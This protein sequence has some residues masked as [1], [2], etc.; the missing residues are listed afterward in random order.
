MAYPRS[1]QDTIGGLYHFARMVDKV[2]LNFSGDLPD[3]YKERLGKGMDGFLC[4]FLGVEYS[5]IVTQVK[6]GKADEKILEWCFENG[7]PRSEFD[8]TLFNKFL[9]KL[10]WRD[11]DNGISKRL[12]DYKHDDG[13]AN[14]T[15]IITIFDLIEVN[16][17]RRD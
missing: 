1:P 13:L 12:E 7:T 4:K 5:E 2:W 8:R 14:R 9:E 10:G 15:D 17:G 11:D 6:A 16:E 3:D